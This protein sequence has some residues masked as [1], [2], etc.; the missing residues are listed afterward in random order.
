MQED[1]SDEVYA[2]TDGIKVC[3]F[4]FSIAVE[5]FGIALKE[6]R[7]SIEGNTRMF[8]HVQEKH[9][10]SVDCLHNTY[11]EVTL[12]VYLNVN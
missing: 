5:A 12:D 3:K 7:K 9:G 1:E 8:V 6:E 10:V 2:L 4:L 11:K